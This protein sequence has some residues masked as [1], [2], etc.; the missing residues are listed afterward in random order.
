MNVS[1]E[2]VALLNSLSTVDLSAFGPPSEPRDPRPPSEPR[3]PRPPSEPRDP[4]PPRA[5]SDPRPPS[6]PRDPRPP[7]APSDPRPPSEP[8]DPRPPRA[9]SEPRALCEGDDWLDRTWPCDD[10]DPAEDTFGTSSDVRSCHAHT[11]DWLGNVEHASARDVRP[12]RARDVRPPRARDVRPSR[13][14]D[15]RPSRARDV[16]PSRARDVRPSRARDVRPS[17]DVQYAGDGASRDQEIREQTALRREQ[18]ALRREQTAL[19]REHSELRREHSELRR[20]FETLKRAVSRMSEPLPSRLS[21][22]DVNKFIRD[23]SKE[24]T[25]RECAGR[26]HVRASHSILEGELRKVDRSK[27]LVDSEL[28]LNLQCTTMA[29]RVKH[30]CGISALTRKRKRT[31]AGGAH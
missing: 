27:D 5:P 14:R 30:I 17:R 31:V 16:R 11:G 13:G 29:N 23:W 26:H 6:E 9:P 18:T 2:T 24:G 3:D 7:R 28:F 1:D 25:C 19:R 8:R 12:S 15:V 20:E 4:R 21:D 22:E 10:H